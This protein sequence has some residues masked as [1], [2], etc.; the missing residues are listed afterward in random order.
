MVSM[1][2]R[3]VVLLVPLCLSCVHGAP[4]PDAPLPGRTRV[5]TLAPEPR[6]VGSLEGIMR[7]F[8]EVVNVGKADPR[9]WG[10]DRTLYSPWIRF[11]AIGKSPTGAHPEV[12][13]WTH[14]QLVDETE[15]LIEGG[16]REREIHRTTRRYGN[17]VHIDSTYE[18]LM[19]TGTPTTSRGLN[20]LELYFDGTRWWIASVIWQSEDAEHPLPPESLP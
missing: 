12:E 13:V 8:Y 16:F 1:P 3:L 11:V 19:G 5:E 18:T 2:N 14:Q 6:D 9:Q 17:I 20:S 7:A 10:R 4:L 15:Q